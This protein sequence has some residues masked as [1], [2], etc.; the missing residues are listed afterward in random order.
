MSLGDVFCDAPWLHSEAPRAPSV[1][2]STVLRVVE[3]RGWGHDNWFAEMPELD[4]YVLRQGQHP[5]DP[6][7][8]RAVRRHGVGRAGSGAGAT[9]GGGASPPPSPS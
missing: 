9:R 3:G 1:R 7:L 2:P 6:R 5:L 4:R 8:R